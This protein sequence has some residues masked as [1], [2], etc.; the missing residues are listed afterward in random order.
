MT[1]GSCDPQFSTRPA[2]IA[3]GTSR[4]GA[5]DY[6]AAAKAAEMTRA[7]RAMMG[8]TDGSRTRDIDIFQ[9]LQWLL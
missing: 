1:C 8:V 6:M 5:S 4:R 7:A 2:P 3:F 9:V